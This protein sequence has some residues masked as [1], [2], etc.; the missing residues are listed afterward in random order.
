M[1][2]RTR[3]LLVFLVLAGGAGGTWFLAKPQAPS[4]ELR[5]RSAPASR[6][7]YLVDAVIYTT[8]SEGR[9]HHRFEADRIEQEEDGD[10]LRLSALRVIYAPDDGVEWELS[11]AESVASGDLSLLHLMNNIE[12]ILAPRS[13]EGRRVFRTDDLTFHAS[14]NRIETDAVVSIRQGNRELTGP[15]LHADLESGAVDCCIP[16][17]FHSAP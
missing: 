15:G 2:N 12:V 5:T 9:I 7:F 17:V 4:V 1:L 6:S 11:A 8:D 14:E 10:D 13:E 16:A 3:N